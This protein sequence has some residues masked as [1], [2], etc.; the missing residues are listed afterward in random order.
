MALSNIQEIVERSLY[1]K[2]ESIAIREG[3]AVNKALYTNDITGITN[4]NTAI[5]NIVTSKGFSIA[6][7]GVGSNQKKY[8]KTIPRIVLI[9]RKFLPGDLGGSPNPEYQLNTTSGAFDSH[10]QPP[11]TSDYHFQVNLVYQKSKEGRVLEAIVSEAFSNRGY[12]KFHNDANKEFFV[13]RYNS[14][15]VEDFERGT[16]EQIY[17]Y[18]AKD[19]WQDDD[20]ITISTAVKITEITVDVE[21]EGKQK[22][23]IEQIKLP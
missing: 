18:E 16:T 20:K 2:L 8:L 15:Q 19:I 4:Y 5:K 21:I 22:T 14:S 11:Q 10:V 6:L 3:Y 1:K 17:L 23:P 13:N 7:F 9:K 12:V